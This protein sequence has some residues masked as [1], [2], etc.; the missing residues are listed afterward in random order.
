[1]KRLL[2]LLT[3]L[4]LASGMAWATHPPVGD[5]SDLGACTAEREG[6][7]Y[8]ILDGDTTSD[9]TTGTGSN[10]VLC[11]CDNSV[12]VAKGS[13]GDGDIEA[14]W[15]CGSGDCDDLI[16][17]TGDTLDASAADTTSPCKSGTSPP[18]T[19]AVDECFF[20]TNATAGSNLFGCTATDT[21]TLLGGGGESPP[22]FWSTGSEPVLEAE[23][24]TGSA[25]GG[26][27]EALRLSTITTADE[28]TDFQIGLIFG[29]TDDTTTDQDLVRFLG[30]TPIEV[31]NEDYGELLIQTWNSLWAQWLTPIYLERDGAVTFDSSP[32]DT[33]VAVEGATSILEFANDFR[34]Q[35]N[36]LCFDHTAKSLAV[37]ASSQCASPNYGLYVIADST[38]SGSMF[39]MSN[40]SN[41][42]Q[43]R[44]SG[45]STGARL[46][47]TNDSSQTRIT[48]R[49][50]DAGEDPSDF[51]NG[52][53][54]VPTDTQATCSGNEG[55]IYYDASLQEPCF[56]DG[57]NW[58]QFDGGGTC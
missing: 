7:L 33:R 37:N 52:V 29:Y 43:A 14:V 41:G 10:T 32:E 58:Q 19:C 35:S 57:T 36:E 12:W 15:T 9:C 24:D 22:V 20:D 48:L 49:A 46:I 53:R 31:G 44:F 13:G 26:I 17:T 42:S 16:A 4:L 47:M 45:E 38:L 11:Q 34:Q 50:G 1:M 23:V 5:V 27:Y 2:I 39:W 3:L 18:G 8:S 54:L 28:S 51:Y 55:A 21:W 30:S 6:R 25:T 56:C 40:E